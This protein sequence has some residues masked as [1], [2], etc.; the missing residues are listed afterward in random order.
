[1][2]LRGTTENTQGQSHLNATT[3]KGKLLLHHYVN[4]NHILGVV[5]LG[6]PAVVKLQILS[7]L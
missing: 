4:G 5:N 6:S 3:V 2:S 7:G 1:M